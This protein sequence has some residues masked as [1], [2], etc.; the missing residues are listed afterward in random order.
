MPT[1]TQG[2]EAG[3]ATTLTATTDLGTGEQIG[4]KDPPLPSPEE[5][6]KRYE[7]A[8]KEGVSPCMWIP[9]EWSDLKSHETRERKAFVDTCNRAD[10]FEGEDA[11]E[12][13]A[14]ML[15]DGAK[16]DSKPVKNPAC[17]PDDDSWPHPFGDTSHV[18]E[19]EF[20]SEDHTALQNRLSSDQD[21]LT[22]LNDIVGNS[23]PGMRRLKGIFNWVLYRT[24]VLMDDLNKGLDL[25]N[26]TQ[27]GAARSNYIEFL[28]DLDD[29][30]PEKGSKHSPRDIAKEIAYG[31]AEEIYGKK[32]EEIAQIL[33]LKIEEGL[34]PKLGEDHA[35]KRAKVLAWELGELLKGK[36]LEDVKKSTEPNLDMKIKQSASGYGRAIK[37]ACIDP[38]IFD[39]QIVGTRVVAKWNPHICSSGI[40]IPHG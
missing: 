2:T 17:P 34:T 3:R 1:P 24:T 28:R 4:Q 19:T 12:R 29:H 22:K 7:T 16:K 40:P 21:L 11:K 25:K 38:V 20:S 39:G 33:K 32:S 8:T 26:E 18:D 9:P 13:I 37:W 14:A 23:S 10:P 6:E 35:K 36:S 30:E 27:Y 15:A 31:K 5:M